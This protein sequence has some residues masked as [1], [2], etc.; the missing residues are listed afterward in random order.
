LHEKIAKKF[1]MDTSRKNFSFVEH[2]KCR[3]CCIRVPPR[4]KERVAL[5]DQGFL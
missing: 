1:L 4:S 5:T 3:N 2:P